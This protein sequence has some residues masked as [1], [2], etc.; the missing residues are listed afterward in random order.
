MLK[1]DLFDE[2]FDINRTETYELSIQLTLNGFSFTVKDSVRNS[3]IALYSQPFEI[4]LNL[5]ADWLQ[6]VKQ[7]VSGHELLTRQFK[8]VLFN[9]QNPVFTVAPKEFFTPEH[10]KSILE[11]VCAIPEMDEVRYSNTTSDL[12]SI[13][14]IPTLL[15]TEWLKIQPKTTFIGTGEPLLILGAVLAKG[16]ISTVLVSNIKPFPYLAFFT[17]GNLNHCGS[18]FAQ[19]QNDTAY[20]TINICQKLNLT[21]AETLVFVMGQDDETEQLSMLLGKYFMS[22]S[23]SL[24]S[25]LNHYTYQLLRYKNQFSTLYNLSLCE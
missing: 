3:F 10:A 7:M 12:V 11:L 1:L 8:K 24:P 9:F 17:S 6:L 19:N 22:S 4:G 5:N 21:P 13:F 25:E 18:I 23:L 14:T 15:A 20:H 2:S 16:S